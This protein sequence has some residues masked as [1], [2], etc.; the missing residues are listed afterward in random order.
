MLLNI[1]KNFLSILAILIPVLAGTAGTIMSYGALTA[2]V[3]LM[4]QRLAR[5]E[6]LLDTRTVAEK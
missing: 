3:E 2:R 4:D 5:I 1:R 6:R